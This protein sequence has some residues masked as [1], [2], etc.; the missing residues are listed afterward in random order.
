MLLSV[1]I[2]SY[3][4]EQLIG[5]TI[6]SILLSRFTD[7]ELIICDDASTDKTVD[8]KKTFAQKEKRI[9][10]HVNEK[11][12]GDYP[13]RNKAATYAKGKYIKYVDSDDAV[14]PHTLGSMVDAMEKFP[15]A[16]FGFCDAKANTALKGYPLFYTGREAL[17][18]HF[19]NN[20]LLLAGPST[21]IIRKDAFDK[22]GGF[23][24]TRYISDYQA[25]LQLCLLHDV[26]V[27][28]PGLVWLRTHAGQENDVGKL[29]YYHLNYNLHRD[30]ISSPEFPFTEKEKKRLLFNYKIL[31]GRRVYQRL[32]KWYGIKRSLQTIRKAG[33]SPLI[34]LTAFLP[35][36]K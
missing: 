36:K 31:L 35:M 28:E 27:M 19:F 7:W 15:S 14:Y 18:T 20:G 12:L 13:N 6:K 34:L 30:F 2:T 32:I 3:N 22:M 1:I 9:Q 16:A 21:S 33:E 8:V 24:G 11:N 26:V 25:W 4:R 29:E 17:K 23:P 10:W 5:E